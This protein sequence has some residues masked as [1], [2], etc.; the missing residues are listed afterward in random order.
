[1][2]LPAYHIQSLSLMD[3]N[4]ERTLDLKHIIRLRIRRY[5]TIFNCYLTNFMRVIYKL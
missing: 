5:G 1:M 3:F 4:M 2:R